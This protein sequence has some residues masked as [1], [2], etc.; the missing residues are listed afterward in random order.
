MNITKRFSDEKTMNLKSFMTKPGLTVCVLAWLIV[1]CLG[2]CYRREPMYE[3]ADADLVAAAG[4]KMMEE[5]LDE[6]MPGAEILTCEPFVTF[7][8]YDTN[9]Y[10][11]DYATGRVKH[12]GNEF[13]FT[14]NTV[15]GAV[16]FEE[17]ADTAKKLDEITEKYLYEMLG[18]TPEN[19]EEEHN[20][21]CYVSVPVRDGDSA[22]AV[23]WIDSFDFGLPP[24][25]EDLEAYVRNPQSRQQLYVEKA[26]LYLTENTDLSVYDME[27]LEKLGDQCGIQFGYIKFVD[28]DQDFWMISQRDQVETTLW[29]YGCLLE[30][31]GFELR[32]LIR[33][34]EEVRKDGTNEL[35]VS[36]KNFNPETDL[37]FEKTEDG[38][39]YYF[40]NEDWDL[41]FT[42]RAY[43][44]SEILKHDYW[45]VY[46]E[47][48]G[49]L[50]ASLKASSKKSD[51]EDS[52]PDTL[53]VE[54]EDGYHVLT[55]KKN[56]HSVS[57]GHVGRL[58]QAN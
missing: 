55:S 29:D 31:D 42:I 13:T 19:A 6:H 9:E 20:F 25:I 43:V 7:S 14:I 48:A 36:D 34:R 57:F 51:K 41:P 1:C 35:T 54:Y 32:G 46:Y 11:T 10:L 22:R 16:Y 52:S 5:W 38:Y 8:H 2:G 28:E 27:L 30:K 45:I 37:V 49:E 23:P 33:I 4:T 17:D 53:W 3:Q 58:I 50:T 44:G 12:G 39:M 56:S 24:G 21:D 47:D 18:L 26:E 40:P 15:T